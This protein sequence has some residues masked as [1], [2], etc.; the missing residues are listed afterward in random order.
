MIAP[1]F[2]KHMLSIS[3]CLGSEQLLFQLKKTA[4][5]AVLSSTSTSKTF[6]CSKDKIDGRSNFVKECRMQFGWADE[7]YQL[8]LCTSM[9]FPLEH[10][11]RCTSHRCYLLFWNACCTKLN[12]LVGDEVVCLEL[13][14]ANGS[15]AK[16][17]DCQVFSVCSYSFVLAKLA[18]LKPIMSWLHCM[19][20]SVVTVEFMVCFILSCQFQLLW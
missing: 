2:N 12:L 16:C 8:L 17:N 15:S 4:H 3:S 7:T 9:M 6:C 1:T 11:L 10:I 20:V 14:L 19:C 5:F 18:S 13:N